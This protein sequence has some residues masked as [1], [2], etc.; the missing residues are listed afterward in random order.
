M[1]YI[2]DLSP[3]TYWEYD[4]VHVDEGTVTFV[5]RY[6]RIAVGW[7]AGDREFNRGIAPV[8]FVD[9]LI[10]IDDERCANATRGFHPCESARLRIRSTGCRGRS[11]GTAL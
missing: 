1:T 7:L 3:Y 10:R 4:S 8:G 11:T 5:P 6:P 9:A 2:A